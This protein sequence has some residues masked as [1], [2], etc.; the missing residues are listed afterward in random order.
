MKIRFHVS[1]EAEYDDVPEEM[2]RLIENTCSRW[3]EVEEARLA[4][5]LEPLK[6]KGLKVRFGFTDDDD[7]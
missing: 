4:E 1:I 6:K 5:A 2:Q 3:A 7:L